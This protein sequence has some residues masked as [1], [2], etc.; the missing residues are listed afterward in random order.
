MKDPASQAAVHV[1]EAL[2]D[3]SPI[4]HAMHAST[5]LL[6]LMVPAVQGT[7]AV[8]PAVDVI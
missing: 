5:L 6:L 2:A 3:H 8:L 1:L 7:Q 4:S